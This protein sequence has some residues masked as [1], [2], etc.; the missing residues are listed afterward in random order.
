MYEFCHAYYL[1]YIPPHSHVL[2]YLHYLPSP[3]NCILVTLFPSIYLTIR[4][5]H[6]RPSL[7][8]GR[9]CDIV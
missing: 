6:A 2:Y 1:L 9:T 8:N 7:A 5:T 3:I 4:L